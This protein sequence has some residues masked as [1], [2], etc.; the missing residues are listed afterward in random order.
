MCR[1]PVGFEFE[2]V[3]HVN[4][5]W[6]IWEKSPCDAGTGFL[7]QSSAALTQ[8]HCHCEMGCCGEQAGR[9]YNERAI[10]VLMNNFYTHLE[11]FGFFQW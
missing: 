4:D 7:E 10:Y 6:P 1:P 2:C 9:I 8:S 11:M 3:R 5:S